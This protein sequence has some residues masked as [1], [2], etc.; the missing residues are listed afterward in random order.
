MFFPLYSAVPLQVGRRVGNY[1]V[2][3]YVDSG[4]MS[5]IWRA[6]D[7]RG[8]EVIIKEPRL[9]VAGSLRY[10][11]H[12]GVVLG[13]IR[14]RNVIELK[15][16]IHDS[17]GVYYL[18]L[19]YAE[20]GSLAGLAGR[21]GAKEVRRLLLELLRGL[22]AAHYHGVIHRDLKP[23]NVLLR[24]G[25]VKVSDF[26]TSLHYRQRALDIVISPGGY[27][28]PEQIRGLSLYQSDVWSAGATALYLLTGVQPCNFIRG[29]DCGN[30]SKSAY[31]QPMTPTTGRY[32]L[33]V[34]IATALQ[35]NY[36]YR[37]YDALEAYQFLKTGKPLVRPDV[38][39]V[40]IRT[41][42]VKVERGEFYIGGTAIR[43]MDL[44]IE[45]DTIFIYDPRG[46][47]APRHVHFY[48]F[49]DGWYVR[50]LGTYGG[51]ALLRDGV[52]SH[53]VPWKWTKLS[54]GDILALGFDQ[55]GPYELVG[56]G[57]PP[58]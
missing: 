13:R 47:I 29:Y 14:H 15:D 31:L 43:E 11:Y 30:P 32:D 42:V 16:F 54:Y 9:D 18:V 25:V 5:L 49:S 40:R 22:A 21:L 39:H 56:I 27:T 23:K 26:G 4:G 50:D 46:V 45:G 8:E 35:A 34:F 44:K 10:I 3:G 48:L 57:L 58:R 37:F 38:L 20:G 6:R 19:E 55:S 24:R 1:T 52:W 12:E 28:A 36:V 33:D 41:L 51:T 2:V 53:L 7:A 17:A